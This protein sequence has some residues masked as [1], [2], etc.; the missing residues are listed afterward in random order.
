[1]LV[2]SRHIYRKLGIGLCIPRF[3]HSMEKGLVFPCYR[4]A[5]GPW[6]PSG[7]AGV[8]R[9]DGPV[10]PH[11]YPKFGTDTATRYPAGFKLF[12]WWAGLDCICS[13][14]GIIANKETADSMVLPGPPVPKTK[15]HVVWG[16]SRHS[17]HAPNWSQTWLL[18]NFPCRV[19]PVQPLYQH[20]SS[21][22]CRGP[23][24]ITSYCPITARLVSLVIP[25]GTRSD[26]LCRSFPLAHFY[27]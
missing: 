5:Y 18:A 7:T 25:L 10:D 2:I 4:S 3:H 12:L 26:V 9:Q 6:E 20:A 21:P 16:D 19:W 24:S 22:S 23:P 27:Y 8:H 17:H 14:L 15:F 1:M 11:H 13:S